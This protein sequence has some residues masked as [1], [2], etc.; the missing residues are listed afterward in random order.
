MAAGSA[1][2]VLAGKAFVQ[3]LADDSALRRGLHAASRRL[4]AFGVGVRRT[5]AGLLALGTSIG[6]PLL[7][8]GRSFATIGDTIHKISLRTG[9]STQ[10]VSE[11]GWAMEQSG[12]TVDD[13][14]RGIR[15]MQRTLGQAAA[16]SE[17]A[18]EALAGLG[19]DARAMLALDPE[20]QFLAIADALASVQ[21][22]ALRTTTALAIFGRS[23]TMLLPLVM[24]GSEGIAAFRQE[25][26]RLG[27]TLATKDAE[28]AAILDDGLRK[29]NTSL[30]TLVL[31]VGSAVSPVLSRAAETLLSVATAT[32][33]WIRQNQGLFVVAVKVAA[34]LTGASVALFALG[35]ALSAA[36]IALKAAAVALGLLLSP[37]GLLTAAIVGLGVGIYRATDIGARALE[38]LATRFEWLTTTA[39]QA[40]QGIAAALRK[41]DLSLAA[42]VALSAL[43]VVVLEATEDIRV[44]WHEL[45]QGI[46]AAAVLTWDAIQVAWIEGAA[47]IQRIHQ[48]LLAWHAHASE[49]LAD[50]MVRAWIWAR[51]QLGMITKEQ[52]DFERDYVTRQHELAF[53]QI[54][55][56]RQQEL[57]AINTSR[58]EALAAQNV[59]T[60]EAL[61]GIVTDTK[62]RINAAKIAAKSAKE[63]FDALRAAAAAPAAPEPAADL[64]A[65]PR[66]D[67]ES[68]FRDVAIAATAAI[69]RTGAAGTFNVA[70]VRGLG[71]GGVADRIAR[72][73]EQTAR[74]TQKL[75]DRG[76]LEFE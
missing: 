67:L 66:P 35:G 10:A 69:R 9:L 14:E 61:A 42:K 32:S 1:R 57:A 71:A 72:A 21:D 43:Q 6:A 8:A 31:R 44:G 28:A 34:G 38:W 39:R 53:A 76:G 45:M 2:G 27:V 24:A 16:G 48:N 30:R 11:L 23:G 4:K 37:V 63:E 36:A 50:R 15:A 65:P 51:E 41:G 59:R 26:Q 64:S 54:E 29:L 75:V 3:L 74:N 60:N 52:A 19:L 18:A 25:A 7:A 17:G 22:A 20:L 5:S 47:A 55:R 12:G 62:A 58:Q 70:E 13:L 68:V 46:R 33:E 73:S 56:A 49:S 40:W